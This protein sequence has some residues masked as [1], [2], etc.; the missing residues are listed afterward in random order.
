MKTPP[1]YLLQLILAFFALSLDAAESAFP[2]KRLIPGS[3]G[4]SLGSSARFAETNGI[5]QV[6]AGENALV[7][8]LVDA[9]P[10]V[11]TH[12][13]R[14]VG[15]VRYDE[16]GGTAFLETWTVF[17]EDRAFSRTLGESGPMAKLSGSSA[18]REFILPMNMD[19]AGASVDRIEFN[20]I[21]PDGGTVS[22]KDLRIEPV[23]AIHGQPWLAIGWL[24][25]APA[26]FLVGSV[27]VFLLWFGKRRRSREEELNRM[28]AADV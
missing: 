4:V 13:Y 21:L 6:V 15:M 16:V 23:A 2:V 26:M 9:Q 5:L 18:W 20:V 10:G 3:D 17:G 1:R 27:V 14:L 24:L 28:M 8:I 22:L 12:S 11:G 25:V 7:P 19:G